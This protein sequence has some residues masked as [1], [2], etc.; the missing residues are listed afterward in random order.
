MENS[1]NIP[2]PRHA[3]QLVQFLLLHGNFWSLRA[4]YLFSCKKLGE[5]DDQ[6]LKIALAFRHDEPTY[7]SEAARFNLLAAKFLI[8][9]NPGK[10]DYEV[11]KILDPEPSPTESDRQEKVATMRSDIKKNNNLFS[12]N[13]SSADVQLLT[14]MLSA[15]MEMI[16]NYDPENTHSAFSEFRS[17]RWGN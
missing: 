16:I 2:A 3:K 7:T 12:I 5:I 13:N 11:N 15:A 10:F 14:D 8:S 1:S 6:N 17:L 4:D 9:K